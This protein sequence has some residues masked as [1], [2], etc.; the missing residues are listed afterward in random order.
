M[1]KEKEA[2]EKLKLP[3]DVSMHSD[4]M[5]TFYQAFDRIDA[6]QSGSISW[7]EIASFL[8]H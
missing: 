6:D 5:N 3:S 4:S 8:G 7:P 1:K 2:L